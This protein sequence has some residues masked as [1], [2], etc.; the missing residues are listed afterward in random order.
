[1]LKPSSVFKI[2][3]KQLINTLK[4]VYK[5][6]KRS[7]EIQIDKLVTLPV[8]FYSSLLDGFTR[9]GDIVFAPSLLII[10]LC[11]S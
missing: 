8:N 11:M 1:M 10:A 5:S 2:V 7:H 9:S 4:T 3:N 6:L